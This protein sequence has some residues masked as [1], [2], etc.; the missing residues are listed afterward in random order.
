MSRRLSRL[1]YSLLTASLLNAAA[2]TD[3]DGPAAD[4]GAR[5]ADASQAQRERALTAALGMDA[6]MAYFMASFMQSVP[7]GVACPSVTRSGS[8]LTV[9]TDCT[10]DG[11]TRL[12]G[13][14][15][16]TNVPDLEGGNFDPARPIELRFEGYRLDDTS[17]DNEDFAFDGTVTMSPDGA[18]AARLT[19]EV[20]GMA[21]T[22]DA[23]WRATTNGRQAAAAGSTVTLPGLGQAEI[24]GT[25]LLED[26]AP[27]GAIELHGADVLRADFD[28]ASNDCVPITIDGAA[29]GELCD[30]AE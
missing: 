16:G 26:P 30:R 5:F 11:G 2:C 22:I 4:D 20:G 12:S 25:W 7:P 9:T 10:D 29:A 14:I 28:R 13:R 17:A 18:F 6:G 15:V 8:T 19:S 27:V 24:Q 23:T 1:F 3:D 21:A